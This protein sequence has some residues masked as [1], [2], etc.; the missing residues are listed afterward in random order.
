[1]RIIL[2]CFFTNLMAI[3]KNQ[4]KIKKHKLGCTFRTRELLILMT[5]GENV[6]DNLKLSEMSSVDVEEIIRINYDDIFKY[7]F[8]RVKHYSDAEDL[9]QETFLRFIDYLSNYSERG[10]P[11]ALLYTIARNLCINWQK[12]IK[13]DIL[14]ERIMEQNAMQQEDDTDAILERLELHKHLNELPVDQQE[15]LLLRYFQELSVNEV[16][17]IM[18]M[19]RFSV[20]YRIR[21]AKDTLRK[22]MGRG[23]TSL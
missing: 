12:R 11:K 15:V 23:Y 14:S 13:P 1:M 22:K 10:K 4:L 5:R 9:T 6:V 8:W 3:L 18:G 16:A 20:M 2:K 7:C 21:V 19:S 17:A